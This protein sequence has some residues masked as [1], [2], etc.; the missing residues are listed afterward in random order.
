MN[1]LYFEKPTRYINSEIN[2]IKKPSK[3]L[4]K[5]ALAFP[6]TYEIGMS[7]VGL[8]ILYQILNNI[9]DVSAERVY[10]P[11]L[12]MSNYMAHNNIPLCSLETKTPLKDFHI[13][14]FS[15]Q[16]ELSY[17]CVL[18]MLH[19][20]QLPIH[21]EERLSKKY[22]L[23]IAGGP[24]A[25]NPLP[26]SSFID[27]FLIGDAE[28]ALVELVD[29]Y[30]NWIKTGESKEELL[31]QI[32]QIPGFYVPLFGSKPVKRRFIKSLEEAPFPL[33]PILP[34]MK[35]VHDRISIEV[36]RG[37][38]A[39]C[40]FCQAGMIYRPLRM[41]S[42]EKVIEIARKSIQS[43]GYEEISLLS[44]SIGHYEHLEE[45]IE[46]LNREFSSSGVA[47]SLPSIRADKVTRELLRKIKFTRKTGFTIAP[48]AAT[49]RLR[50]V[51]NKNITNEHIERACSLL[52]EEG[53]LSVKLYF[54]IGL[55]TER[56]ED[57]E[58]IVNLTRSIIKLAR[59]KTKKFV[60][61]NVTVSPFIP[62]PHTP[63]QWLGQIGF[64]EMEKKLDYIKMAFERSKIHY[65]GH[66]PRMSFLEAALS[67]GDERIGKVIKEVWKSGETLSAWTEGFLFERWLS[68]MD[69]TGIDLYSYA[70]RKYELDDSLPWNFIH[71][72]IKDDFLK[73]EYQKA[74]N[75]ERTE[76]CTK[77]C[78][79]CG[80]DGCI[81][82]LKKSP[83][84][85][86]NSINRIISHQKEPPLENT[87]TLVRFCHQKKGSMKYLSQ[88]ELGNLITRVLRMAKIPF[89]LSKGF[90][91][92][93]EIS[94][95]PSLSVGIESEAEYFDLKIYGELKDEYINRMNKI[96]P[97]GLKIKWAKIIEPK[98]SSLGAFIERYKY[99]VSLPENFN[100][101]N[102]LEMEHIQ[103][104][105]KEKAYSI[106][107]F[108]EE[109]QINGTEACIIVKDG[110]IK[111]RITEIVEALFGVSWKDLNIKR[112]E[113][114]GYKGGWVEP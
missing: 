49:E 48:E 95:G 15:L 92:K 46:R 75:L 43:T 85:Y 26:M 52:F 96:L 45:L 62:K 36:S 69:K 94:F 39:G 91:P 47:I 42:P 21:T 35:I 109:F 108:I 61:L 68:A 40:R 14:G 30:R 57:V 44:F 64:E 114:T 38:P 19:L 50:S 6:D 74:L 72:N 76:E 41:R 82:K 16:Y 90:H 97:E 3:D 17:P 2:A 70:T 4:I 34:Y 66:D 79:N 10:S 84:L 24:C 56:D 80:I 29:V 93:P 100:A 99:R 32:G 28:E 110:E 54:M 20:G 105:R 51:I 67:R 89:V 107:N 81:L 71:S 7:H 60:D 59:K 37:C 88:I 101:K 63:F 12:D 33:S 87:V 103:I 5:F 112:I 58:E 23:I 55:P 8:K 86:V 27:A 77:K 111:A 18:N 83:S 104:I 22:P 65:K 53:W 1:L 78:G 11:W 102:S 13:I 73:L 98:E 25:S 31:Q 113:M 9:P 106:K